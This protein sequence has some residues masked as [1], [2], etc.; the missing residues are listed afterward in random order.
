MVVP[1]FPP[2]PG[3]DAEWRDGELSGADGGVQAHIPILEASD[4]SKLALLQGLEYLVQISFVDDDE[5]LPPFLTRGSMRRSLGA[6]KI[7]ILNSVHL[8]AL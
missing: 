6:L 7:V 4:E 1:P 3:P 8:T 5:V 2:R